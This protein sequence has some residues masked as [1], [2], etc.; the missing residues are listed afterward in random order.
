MNRA[1]LLTHQLLLQLLGDFIVLEERKKERKK[2][3]N[4]LLERKKESWKGIKKRR[5]RS[6][7]VCHC[8]RVAMFPGV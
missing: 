6:A 8:Q 1:V 3:R 2:E 7:Y 5:S 4:V